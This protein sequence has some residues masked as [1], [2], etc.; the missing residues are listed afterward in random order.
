MNW[1]YLV[2]GSGQ[3]IE[4]EID[5]ADRDTGFS[6]MAR[7]S[8]PVGN[9]VWSVVRERTRTSETRVSPRFSQ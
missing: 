7:T 8:Q 9:N 2:G 4:N 5:R 6:G 1:K 3:C